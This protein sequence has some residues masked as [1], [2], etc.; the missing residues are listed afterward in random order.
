M[1]SARNEKLEQQVS[2]I[3]FIFLRDR[4]FCFTSISMEIPK[5]SYC[6]NIL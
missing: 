1:M 6:P 4:M 3:L 5:K 2:L